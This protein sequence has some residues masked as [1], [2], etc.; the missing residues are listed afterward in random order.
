MANSR[1]RDTILIVED[2]PGHAQ[3][4]VKNLRRAGMEASFVIVDD[5]QQALDLLFGEGEYADQE[6]SRPLLVILDL[7]LPVRDGFQ[8]LERIKS[9]DR[10]RSIP[11]I[12]LTCSDDR[13]DVS[14]CLDLGCNTFVTKPVEY[15]ALSNVIRKLGR[16]LSMQRMPPG[17]ISC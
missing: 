10:L 15:E 5:G 7:N 16:F 8:V 12:V 17:A 3:L 4:I 1:A 9:D 14:R 11:V 2:D 6:R 13:G